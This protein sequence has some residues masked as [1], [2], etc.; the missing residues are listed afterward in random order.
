[1]CID[2]TIKYG[3]Q[4]QYTFIYMCI[5]LNEIQGMIQSE[6][7]KGGG[8]RRGLMFLEILALKEYF[9]G[10]QAPYVHTAQLSVYVYVGLITMKNTLR[11]KIKA[12]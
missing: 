4:Q 7:G 1:M 2:H 10:L 11:S 3:I 5:M 9:R 8:G 6:T 12:Y